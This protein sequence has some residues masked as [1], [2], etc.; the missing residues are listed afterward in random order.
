[1]LKK[2][3]AEL[4]GTMFLVITILGSVMLGDLFNGDIAASHLFHS[5]S[6]GVILII[7]ISMFNQYSGAHFNPVV[8]FSFFLTK[9]IKINIFFL[10]VIAQILG[11]IMGSTIVNLMYEEN[12]FIISEI[13]RTGYGKYFSELFTT[14]GLVFLIHMLLKSQQHLIPILVGGY[15]FVVIMSSSST[16]FTNPVVS[17]SRIFTAS[18]AGIDPMSSMYYI[19][20]QFL[21][22]F[23]ALYLSNL[24][25]KK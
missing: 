20:T 1:M 13:Q 24:F 9:Q 15:I 22:V 3:L 19:L 5:L 25:T 11:G 18:S 8:T 4:L 14:F 7:L 2:F 23:F 17:I 12:I 10:Y 6:V 21:S 16:A